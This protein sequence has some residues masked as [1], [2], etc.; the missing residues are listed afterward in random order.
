MKRASRYLLF[1]SIITFIAVIVV[2]IQDSYQKLIQTQEKITSDIILK[3][4]NPQ[5][6]TTVL[7]ELQKRT[8]YSVTSPNPTSIQ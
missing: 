8:E 6:D 4:I 2:I 1:I 3:P 7:D 5:L